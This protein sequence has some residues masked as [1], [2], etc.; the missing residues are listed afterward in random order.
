MKTA[1]Y[2]RVSKNDGTQTVENQR[3][4]LVSYAERMSYEVVEFVD[5]ETGSRSDP[6]D[7]GLYSMPAA[8]GKCPAYCSGN[9][10]VSRVWVRH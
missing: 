8:G 3:R 9:W 4:D 6:T 2:M 1:L 7:S 5:H 10:T